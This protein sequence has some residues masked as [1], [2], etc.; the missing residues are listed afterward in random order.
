MTLKDTLKLCAKA[1]LILYFLLG[2]AFVATRWYLINNFDSLRNTITQEISEQ[3]QID[4]KAKAFQFDFY[5]FWPSIRLHNVQIAR[6]NGP[7]SL[8]LPY[9]KA[10][11]NWS[12]LWN[13]APHFRTLIVKDPHLTIRRLDNNHIDIAGFIFNIQSLRKVS[14]QLPSTE[15]SPTKFESPAFERL[16]AQTRLSLQNGKIQYIDER[17]TQDNL[18]TIENVEFEFQN[19]LFQWNAALRGAIRNQDRQEKFQLKG[20]INDSLFMNPRDPSTWDMSLY[21]NFNQTDI[22][23]IAK[24]LRLNEYMDS[25]KGA[26][27]LWFQT[28]NGKAHSLITDIAA[29]QVNVRLQKHLPYLKVDGALGRLYFSMNDQDELN[30]NAQHLELWQNKNWHFGPMSVQSSYQPKNRNDQPIFR[31]SV[32]HIDLRTLSKIGPSFPLHQEVRQFLKQWPITG[33]IHDIQ[34]ECIGS[35]TDLNHWRFSGQFMNLSML[36]QSNMPSVRNLSGQFSSSHE[37]DTLSVSIY[38][39]GLRLSFPGIFAR[40]TIRLDKA[41]AQVKVHFTPTVKVEIP[42]FRVANPDALI[43]GKASWENTGGPGTLSLSGKI[44][45]A[46]GTQVVHYLPNV[47]GHDTLHWLKEGI[48]AGDVTH[49]DYE[50]R[51]PLAQFPWDDQKEGLFRIRAHVKNGKLNLQPSNHRKPIWPFLE[52]VTADLLFEGNRMLIQAPYGESSGLIARNVRVEIPSYFASGTPLLAHAHIRGD[53]QHVMQYLNDA[54][55]IHNAIGSHFQE[56]KA[57]GKVTADLRLHLPLARLQESRY[58]VRADFNDVSFYYGLRLPTVKNL[59]GSIDV[60]RSGIYTPERILGHLNAE[61]FSLEIQQ[62][63]EELQLQIKGQISSRQIAHFVQQKALT[64]Y[65]QGSSDLNVFINI[66]TALE[67]L[68]VQGE[69]SLQGLTLSF[70]R[71]FTKPAD[72]FW[73]INFIWSDAPKLTSLTINAPDHLMGQWNFLPFRRHPEWALQS[74]YLEIGAP[75]QT[76][77]DADFLVQINL[78]FLNLDQWNQVLQQ[79]NQH[80]PKQDSIQPRDLLPENTLVHTNIDQMIIKDY[81]VHTLQSTIR[82]FNQQNWHVRIKA[83]EVSGQMEYHPNPEQLIVKLNQLYLPDVTEKVD[84]SSARSKQ[85]GVLPDISLVIDDLRLRNRILGKVELQSKNQGEIYLINKLALTL[86]TGQCMSHGHWLRTPNQNQT[87]LNITAQTSDLGNILHNLG[88]KEVIN[89]TTGKLTAKLEWTGAPHQPDVSTLS[90]KVESTFSTGQILP[91][92]P[93]AGRILNLLSMQHL[94]RRL[95]L[96]FS[97][98]IQKGFAFDSISGTYQIQKGIVR[99]HDTALISPSATI[100]LSGLVYLPQ[101]KL[102]ITAKVL[103]KFNAE[104]AGLALTIANPAI[105]IGTLVG[106]WLLKDEISKFLSF[107]YKISGS[108][109][110]PLIR[111]NEKGS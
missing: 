77:H 90:G 107:E 35:F 51:G 101:E 36:A 63:E 99:T 49:G 43:T 104:A 52:N 46:K 73:P 79:W 106:Q 54:Y 67:T 39:P 103:P 64:R 38:S 2:V 110:D 42:S 59:K 44:H 11:F 13:V 68:R 66:N 111:K 45:R 48:L 70:P 31:L 61:P 87:H 89:K 12:S 109:S 19:N 80:I 25:G 21:A 26:I 8:R 88:I 72:E 100:F 37:S 4:L 69:S 92:E 16:L 28:T 85:T 34:A 24:R 56:T 1:L 53:A 81:P 108:F 83:K 47:I 6:I 10:I 18:V 75:Y 15:P 3:F 17:R 82:L 23:S 60:S 84:L 62:K 27:R 55:Y 91:I 33:A 78:P 58:H 32:S 74:G 40:P 41:Q 65:I 71:P 94:L 9:I 57:Q 14:Q 86:P 7:T 105:G 29:Y 76:T 96:D 95:T 98:V 102:D 22:G 20:L 50:V 30:I 93:G 97:D 5:Y